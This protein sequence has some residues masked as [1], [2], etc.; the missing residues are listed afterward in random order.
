ML[1]EH[2]RTS[3]AIFLTPARVKLSAYRVS[4]R[5]MREFPNNLNNAYWIW[6]ARTEVYEITTKKKLSSIVIW[7]V[8]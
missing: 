1:L 8:I 7:C 2:A 5:K 6:T 4:S 3:A